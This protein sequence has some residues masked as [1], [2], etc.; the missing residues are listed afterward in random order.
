MR[1]LVAASLLVAALAV[2]S[3]HAGHSHPDS[4]KQRLRGGPLYKESVKALDQSMR[5]LGHTANT[6]AQYW[7][8][9]IDPATPSVGTFKQKFYEDRSY[10]SGGNVAFLYILGEGPVGSSVQGQPVELAKNM[11]A[12]AVTLEHRYYGESMPAPWDKKSMLKYLSVKLAM[13]DFNNFTN[14]YNTREGK[15]LTWFV[16]GGSYAGGLSAWL[17]TTY[18]ETFVASWSSSGVVN[19]IFNFYEFDNH[20]KHV[21]DP[22]CTRAIQYVL[23][24]VH[25]NWATEAGRAMVRSKLGSPDYFTLTDLQWMLSDAS[26]Q[27]VQYGMKDK[28]CNGIQ[29]TN[30]ADPLTQYRLMIESIWG[31]GFTSNCGYSTYCLKNETFFA[32]GQWANADYPWVY[33]ICSELGWWQNGYP[34]SIRPENVSTT[35][36]LNQCKEVFWPSIFSDTYSFDLRH[37]GADPT[38]KGASRVIALQGSDDPWQTAGVRQTLSSDYIEVTAQCTGC[39]HCGDLF[40]G[41]TVPGI[42]HQQKV[43]FEL[44][45]KWVLGK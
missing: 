10:Y 24:Y 26:A 45:N 21:L 11:S 29:P 31:A 40:S 39:G 5:D 27:A 16:V 1:H 37:G 2:S 25:G 3:V 30:M 28:M 19:P 22:S 33:Q 18:P 38:T 41:S 17:R 4:F 8:P 20:V 12:L 6:T 43:T 36:F 35:Y 7:Y 42:L 14:F 32:N 15:K 34:G 13:G 44:L 23:N 9:P